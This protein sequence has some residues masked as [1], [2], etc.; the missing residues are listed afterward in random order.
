MSSSAANEGQP[1]ARSVKRFLETASW[2]CLGLAVAAALTVLASNWGVNAA[3]LGKYNPALALF[4]SSA[5]AAALI[6]STFAV[7]VLALAGVA[8]LFFQP[9]A[10]LRFFAATVVAALPFAVLSW[11]A[12]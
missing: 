4:F 1:Q 11:L 6:V 5:G 7:P 8:S 12:G 9:F 3:S 10:A 2:T